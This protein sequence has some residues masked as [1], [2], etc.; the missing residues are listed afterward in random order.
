MSLGYSGTIVK[1]VG[2]RDI[3]GWSGIYTLGVT[4][5]VPTDLFDL[6]LT[7]GP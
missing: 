3:V 1:V 2:S 4:C 6:K 7:W 5:D